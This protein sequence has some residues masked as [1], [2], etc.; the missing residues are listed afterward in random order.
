AS[1][2]DAGGSLTF[3]GGG[4]KLLADVSDS[5][6]FELKDLANVVI[7]TNGQTLTHLGSIFPQAGANGGLVKNGAGTLVLTGFNGFLGPTIVNGGTL[8]LSNNA[9]LGDVSAASRLVLNGATLVTTAVMDLDNFGANPRPVTISGATSFDV[10]D[11][12]T[13]TVR[14]IVDGPGALTK[15]S[16]GTLV[17]SGANTYQGP[18]TL[19]GGTLT[20]ANNSAL[21]ASASLTM[22][23]GTRLHLQGGGTLFIGLPIFTTP[24]AVATISSSN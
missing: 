12:T 15:T 21:G 22:S 7:D 11:T 6:M 5:R 17:L 4:I 1:L 3:A 18:T 23:D 14:G 16:N 20:V 9:N 24:G 8:S 2:G 10:A 13:L 19:Q